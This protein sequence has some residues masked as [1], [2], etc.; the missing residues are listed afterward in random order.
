MNIKTS[1][2]LKEAIE[3]LVAGESGL[4]YDIA[5]YVTYNYYMNTHIKV[6]SDEDV[7]NDKVYTEFKTLHPELYNEVELDVDMLFKRMESDD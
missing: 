5:R 4:V 7:Q 3:K 2:D 6:G 1:K